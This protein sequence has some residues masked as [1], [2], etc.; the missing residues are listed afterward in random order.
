[1]LDLP[2]YSAYLH[3]ITQTLLLGV[4]R[5]ADGVKAEM[6]D[7][8][9]PAKPKVSSE[10]KLGA[11]FSPLETEPHAFLY[12]GPSMLAVFPL[13]N[14]GGGGAPPSF[15]GA[16]ALHAGPG[17]PLSEAGR[18][19]HTNAATGDDAPVDRALVV[20]KTLYTLSYLGLAENDLATLAP[21]GFTKF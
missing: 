10:L 4:G 2:G 14:P 5:D 20:G 21:T 18:I 7:V 11:G 8:S 19:T 16:V 17:A 1:Q 13:E 9:D 15:E 12:W 6:F 3:P